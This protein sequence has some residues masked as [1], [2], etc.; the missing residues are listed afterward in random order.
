MFF[1]RSPGA[2]SRVVAR[3]AAAN[4]QIDTAFITSVGRGFGADLGGLAGAD[5]HCQ[6]LAAAVG[7]GNRTWRAYLSAPASAGRP[8]VHARDRI[9]QGP[10]VNAKGIQIASEC[11]GPAQRRQRAR[12]RQLAERE[13]HRHRPWPPRHPDRHECRRHAG[14]RRPGHDVPGMDQ[15]WRGPRH[16]RPSQPKRRRSAP[17]VLELC[18]P[19]EGLQP[20]G[21]SLDARRRAHLLLRRG[22]V[23]CHRALTAL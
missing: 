15:P 23:A 17:D 14:H 11:G 3:A 12:S 20:G 1:G 16:A 5:A 6:Q 4:R 22:L 2:D 9:G 7:Q 18:A 21:P 8:A 13:G 19:V 10:W